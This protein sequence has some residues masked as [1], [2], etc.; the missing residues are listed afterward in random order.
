MSA[1]TSTAAIPT[2]P[3]D[4][5]HPLQTARSDLPAGLVVFLVALPLCLGIALASGV[6]LLSGI[7]AGIVGGLVVPLVSRAPLS[8]SGPA[9]GLTAIVLT[10]VAD[11]GSFEAFLTATVLAGVL[12]AGLGALRAGGLGAL[13]PSSVIK[14]ML[15]AIGLILILKQ[16]PHAVGYDVESFGSDAFLAPTGENTFSLITHALSAFEWGAVLISALSLALLIGWPKTPFGK[17]PFLP[18]ALM[19]VLAGTG[20][21]MLLLAYA[22][23]MALAPTHLVSLPTVDGPMG[24]WAALHS[25]DWGALASPA[26]WTVAVTI[27]L[28]ASIETLLSVE[29]VDGLD[30]QRRATPTSRELVAQGLGN[31]VSGFL[32]GLPITS[33]IVRSSANVAAGGRTRL[34]AVV[35]GAFLLGAVLFLSRYIMMVPLACLAAILLQVGYKLVRPSLVRKLWGHGMDQ[36]VPFAVTVV[37]I[38]FTD[39]LRGV[40]VGLVV[41]LVFVL[42]NKAHRTF[43]MAQEG[44]QVVLRINKDVSFIHVPALMN[45]LRGLPDGTRLKI[46]ATG[47]EFIDFDIREKL[48]DFVESAPLRGIEVELEGV[49]ADMESRRVGKVQAVVH[50]RSSPLASEG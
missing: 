10:G 5:I 46:D 40:L 34:S 20:V 43:T 11:L 22:P 17:L 16:L 7:V 21:N 8:V 13:V 47:A 6:P 48:Q 42:R 29:A 23:E 38:L 31:T 49:Y 25:P 24:L 3:L 44:E 12:Q 19:V 2:R 1:P 30:P 41:G 33:V 28:V 9:A 15:A 36:F 4:E 35:H 32:G 14:G 37:A 27:A 26:T 50:H 39:L 18:A 45:V